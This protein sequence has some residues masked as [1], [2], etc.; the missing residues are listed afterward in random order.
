MLAAR[1]V[2]VSHQTVR[3]WAKKFSGHFANVSR[4]DQL[5]G[6]ATNGISMRL[7]SPSVERAIHRG[8]CRRPRA[9]GR[10]CALPVI[11]DLSH[12][13]SFTLQP[14]STRCGRSLASCMPTTTKEPEPADLEQVRQKET[15]RPIIRDHPVVSFVG[16]GLATPCSFRAKSSAWLRGIALENRKP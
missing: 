9:G 8:H 12:Y 4:S 5:A 6:S 13:R 16:G 3:F 2:I 15:N 7:S 11:R 14:L 1:G 10:G